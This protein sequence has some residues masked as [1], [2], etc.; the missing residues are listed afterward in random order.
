MIKKKK[1]TLCRNTHP[2]LG[3]VPEPAAPEPDPPQLTSPA[4]PPA[5]AAAPPS[6]GCGGRI[7]ASAQS[8]SPGHVQAERAQRS[9][10]VR[11]RML[12]GKWIAVSNHL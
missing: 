7:P 3:E 2:R 12:G 4:V 9:A 5:S 1:K 11:Q 6:P 10:G 8:G